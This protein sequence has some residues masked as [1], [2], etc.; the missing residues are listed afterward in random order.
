ML[1]AVSPM[2]QR[3]SVGKVVLHTKSLKAN[4]G[5]LT[6]CQRTCH[7]ACLGFSSSTSAPRSCAMNIRSK[8]FRFAKKQLSNKSYTSGHLLCPLLRRQEKRECPLP[9]NSE[10]T[11]SLL[12]QL[13]PILSCH[14]QH[15]GRCTLIVGHQYFT[16]G[17]GILGCW[18]VMAE[19]L[20]PGQTQLFTEPG[21]ELMLFHS[22]SELAAPLDSGF[23]VTDFARSPDSL[24]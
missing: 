9:W 15:R 14:P 13:L 2:S 6:V 24:V 23:G 10:R 21:A 8:H 22:S 7:A 1:S 3:C 12:K 4:S 19:A 18:Q 16:Y 5:C 17:P 20:S 11:S